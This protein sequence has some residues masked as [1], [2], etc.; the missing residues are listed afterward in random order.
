MRLLCL[1]IGT[2]LMIS[3][4]ACTRQVRPEPESAE[5]SA[6]YKWTSTDVVTAFMEHGLEAVKTRPG[7]I[8][9]VH[10]GSENTIFLMPSI[11]KDIGGL[12]SSFNSEESLQEFKNYYSDIN[13]ET[14]KPPWRIFRKDNILLM[15]SGK[16]PLWKSRQYEQVLRGIAKK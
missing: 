8:V 1:I 4:S 6:F 5:Q 10:Q 14:E 3:A 7:F 11:G 2:L 13:E 9:G 15:I 12:V 16:V